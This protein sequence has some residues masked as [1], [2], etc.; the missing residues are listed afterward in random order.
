VNTDIDR[1]GKGMKELHNI[2][3]S[4]IELALSLWFLQRLLGVAV[5]APTVFLF[6]TIGLA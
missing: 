4:V 6:G 2:Y 5:A 3:S 1:I